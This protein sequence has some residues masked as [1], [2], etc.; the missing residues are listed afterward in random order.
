MPD[1]V[2]KGTSDI[3]ENVSS[4][5]AI[6][7]SMVPENH[8]LVYDTN[9]KTLVP[10]LLDEFD[11]NKITNLELPVHH[12]TLIL[13]EEN[14]NLVTDLIQ[15]NNDNMNLEDDVDSQRNDRA[16]DFSLNH[17]HHRDTIDQPITEINEENIGLTHIPKKR[18]KFENSIEE[19][20]KLKV[21]E[22][23]TSHSVQQIPCEKSDGFCFKKTND[24]F[25]HY[26]LTSAPTGALTP[27]SDRR[28][29][30]PSVNKGPHEKIIQHIESFHPMISHYR[31]DHAPNVRYLPGDIN[32]ALVHGDF[33]DKCPEFKGRVSYDL[34][35]RIVK[36]QH[37]SFAQLG[38]EECEKCEQFTLHGHKQE[39][40]DPT[41]DICEQWNIHNEL[42]TEARTA[43]KDFSERRLSDDM[44]CFSGD[45]QKIIM[46]PRVD[47]FKKVLFIKR[48]IAYHESFARWKKNIS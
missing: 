27:P 35:R 33:L 40:L 43:Y 7:I 19:R 3:V 12:N 39:N 8:I 6:I 45:M 5:T 2:K 29:K 21:E 28:G 1:N 41:C 9:T 17:N 25:V 42:V 14:D 38:H 22:M 44:I 34:Y 15:E 11:F 26:T 24:R 48:L 47:M 31:R 16:N 36:E 18:R 4:D 10:H 37:I 13:S 23:K 30:Q 46:L 32:I 20:K